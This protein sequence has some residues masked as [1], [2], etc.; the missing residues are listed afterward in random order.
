MSRQ[1]R[2]HANMLG[3]AG[4]AGER[5]VDLQRQHIGHVAG[6][7]RTRE[8]VHV[9]QRVHQARRVIQVAQGRLAVGAGVEVDDHRRRTT[10]AHMHPGTGQQQVV[11]RVLATQ[12]HLPWQRFQ[13]TPDQGSRKQQAA[14]RGQRTA[15]PRDQC[16][17]TGRRVGQAGVGQDLQ[18]GL[19]AI[20]V[21]AVRD[22]AA[23]LG[24]GSVRLPSLRDRVHELLRD[25]RLLLPS[26]RRELE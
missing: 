5:G 20:E 12:H 11:A 8:K 2:R 26:P 10:R 7:Q 18:R 14:R 22:E 23:L 4:Q 6:H 21:L 19:R 3:R 1:G 17:D 15:R 9:L 16:D 24:H 25:A 13:A